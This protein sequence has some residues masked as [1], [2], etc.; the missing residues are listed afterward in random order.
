ML[1][2]RVRDRVEDRRVTHTHTQQNA[3]RGG[4]QSSAV[5]KCPGRCASVAALVGTSCS[6]GCTHVISKCVCVCEQLG[7]YACVC[8]SFCYLFCTKYRVIC[9]NKLVKQPIRASVCVCV[10]KWYCWDGGLSAVIMRE[11]LRAHH[12]TVP[13]A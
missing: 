2:A 1:C 12:Q 5:R 8:C 13:D 11:M 4:Y 10:Y 9:F 6:R 3:Q 7:T